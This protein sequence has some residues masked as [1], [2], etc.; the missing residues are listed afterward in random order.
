MRGVACKYL[1]E[2]RDR[3]GGGETTNR[4]EDDD[5]DD[6]AG[7][8]CSEDVV[9]DVAES[10]ACLREDDEAAALSIAGRVHVRE[11]KKGAGVGE[12]EDSVRFG[13]VRCD[14]V[15]T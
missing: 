7:R 14:A 1:V 10:E 11:K 6:T 8:R 2:M 4:E 15:V 9:V 13:T 12:K 3:G 5:G